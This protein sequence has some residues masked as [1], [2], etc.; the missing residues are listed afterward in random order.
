[1]VTRQRNRGLR[2]LPNR[3]LPTVIL[4]LH[5][6]KMH[7]LAFVTCSMQ[8]SPDQRCNYHGT[9]ALVLQVQGNGSMCH[10]SR[11]DDLTADKLRCEDKASQELLCIQELLSK[12]PLQQFAM[13]I[14]IGLI[15]VN[16]IH[17]ANKPQPIYLKVDWPCRTFQR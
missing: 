14:A 5:A 4:P 10:A 11:L 2:P 1:M 13:Q 7:P 8:S 9:S 15:K 12:Q 3:P 16:E 6:I 17:F